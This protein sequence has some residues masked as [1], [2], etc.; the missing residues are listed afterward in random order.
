MS[1]DFSPKVE[2]AKDGSVFETKEYKVFSVVIQGKLYEVWQRKEEHKEGEWNGDINNWWVKYIDSEGDKVEWIPW[3]PR[4]TNRP[5]WDIEICVQNDMRHKSRGW[6]ISKAGF[7]YI[8]CDLRMVYR[9]SCMDL[10][11]AFSRSQYLIHQL[12]EHPFNFSDPDKEIGR[13]IYY[14]NQPGII[15]KFSF[16]EVYIDY[17]GNG[18]GFDMTHPWDGES[19]WPV[20]EWNGLKSIRDDVLTP[21]IWWFRK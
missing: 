9:F 14:R 16:G 8:K 20:S 17:D 3:L 18:T 15:S 1:D 12:L 7:V 10:D 6:R 4:F 2:I 11:Y 19:D 5:S 13:K 21:N